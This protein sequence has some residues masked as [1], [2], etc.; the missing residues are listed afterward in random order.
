MSDYEKPTLLGRLV[1]MIVVDLG[2]QIIRLADRVVGEEVARLVRSDRV[3]AQ[4]M[5]QQKMANDEEWRARMDKMRAARA[6]LDEV[7]LRGCI[8]CGTRLE[9]VANPGGELWLRCPDKDCV[10]RRNR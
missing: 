6:V 10:T 5:W 1:S 7:A 4:R 9:V 2:V 8:S 3:V